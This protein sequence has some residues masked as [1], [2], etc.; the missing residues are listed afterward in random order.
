[1]AARCA[2]YP[3][4]WAAQR[5][6]AMIR[7]RPVSRETRTGQKDASQ[8]VRRREGKGKRGG[9]YPS[10][11]QRRWAAPEP[12]SLGRRTSPPLSARLDRARRGTRGRKAWFTRARRQRALVKLKE[13]T[14]HATEDDACG[15][16]GQPVPVTD[17]EGAEYRTRRGNARA[18]KN[19][20]SPQSRR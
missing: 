6:R 13:N 5:T 9:S 19:L 2:T 11:A 18:D 14:M 15:R 16:R 12:G 3:A 10:R 7:A 17:P 20:Q 4:A 8:S 1:M